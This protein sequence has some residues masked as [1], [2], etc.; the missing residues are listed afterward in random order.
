MAITVTFVDFSCYI[1]DRHH[2][3]SL[4]S[5]LEKHGVRTTYVNALSF[6]E[7]VKQVSE[8][9]PDLLLYSAVATDADVYVRFDRLVKERLK[10]RSIMGGPAPTYDHGLAK[11]NTIDAFC[12]G[13]GELALLEHIRSGFA[14]GKNIILNGADR[15]EGLHRFVDLDSIP[16]PDRTLVYDKD[17]ILRHMSTKQFMMGRGCPYQCT[18]C[19]N[20]AFQQMFRGCGKVVRVKSVDYVIDEVLYTQKRWPSQNI[21]FHDDIFLADR[22]WFFEFC[23]R[24]PGKVGLPYSILARVNNLDEAVVKVLK[25]S[26]CVFV[27]WSLECANDR[28]RNE[29][30]KRRM[31]RGQI[32]EA[33]ARLN[34]CGIPQKM[35][36]LL[37]L[38]GETWR[39]MRETLEMN[40]AIKPQISLATIF[41]P[42][43][44]LEITRY[45]LAQGF[46]TEQ[47]LRDLPTDYFTRTVLNYSD[48][49]KRR[50]SRLAWLFPLLVDFP[51][52]SRNERA[53]QALLS[54]PLPDV[55]LRM[56]FEVYFLF[57]YSRQF[58]VK[59]PWSVSWLV[60]K[61]HV[62]EKLGFYR[63]G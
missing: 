10:V 31:T 55:L 11:G 62:G 36:N 21:L 29:V 5:Y 15:P 17:P 16:I 45:A 44:G 26:G 30:L 48:E 59:T 39:D 60:L 25:E 4:A 57:K 9:K 63:P 12:L 14:G 27:S 38:P 13:E 40:I 52:L 42:Y 18:Y 37:G 46:V 20:E 24:F 53:F 54:L 1:F 2:V 22:K 56:F 19:H 43:P 51:V 33:G 6:A 58:K 7:A 50:I 47:A 28:L 41:T 49:D 3:Y 32:A 61:R 8:L 23:E 35:G 34:R